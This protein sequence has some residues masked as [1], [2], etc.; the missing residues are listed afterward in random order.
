MT[1]ANPTQ[2]EYRID[3]VVSGA[4]VKKTRPGK[5]IAGFKSA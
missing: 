2:E 4:M 1:I 3:L 5:N